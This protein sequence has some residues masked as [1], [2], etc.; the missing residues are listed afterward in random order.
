MSDTIA[1]DIDFKNKM[2]WVWTTLKSEKVPTL[3]FSKRWTFCR[4]K[5]E[6][7]P[8]VLQMVIEVTFEKAKIWSVIDKDDN[9]DY[10]RNLD[11]DSWVNPADLNLSELNQAKVIDS[12]NHSKSLIGNISVF[13][14]Q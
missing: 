4:R 3:K 1:S 10:Y 8:E 7:V 11:Y 12:K 13:E 6:N 9:L 5:E 2:V 14:R